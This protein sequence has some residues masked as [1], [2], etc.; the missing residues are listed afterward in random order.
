MEEEYYINL[1]VAYQNEFPDV[2]NTKFPILSVILTSKNTMNSK[3]MIMGEQD[4]KIEK[5]IK[6]Q[7]KEIFEIEK[8]IK[9]IY[10]KTEEE[11]LNQIILNINGK[12]LLGWNI[13]GF[14]I[15]Y[16]TNRVKK[17]LNIDLNIENIFDCMYDNNIR[18]YSSYS[19]HYIAKEMKIKL[20]DYK[21]INRIEANAI[22]NYLCANINKSQ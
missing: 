17:I 8:D 5:S 12:K 13:I 15:P 9:F 1:E 10:F 16:L 3:C 22:Y 6:D 2:N 21:N 14:D 18:G 20:P 11:L 19:I 4:S 7:I